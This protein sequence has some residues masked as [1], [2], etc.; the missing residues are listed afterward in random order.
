MDTSKIIDMVARMPGGN[1]QETDASCAYTQLSLIECHSLLGDATKFVETWV[2]IPSNSRPTEWVEIGIK[3]PVC[4][5]W[6]N[7]YGHPIAGLLW[8]NA[9]HHKITAAGFQPIDGWECLY[10]NKE[11]KVFL[12]VH[13]DD[14]KIAGPKPTFNKV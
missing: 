4:R 3:Y 10:L 6:M 1:G 9:A 8:Q 7:L 2:T 5:L 12:S 11:L 14:F 13:V